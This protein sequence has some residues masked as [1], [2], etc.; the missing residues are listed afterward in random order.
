[1]KGKN[2]VFFLNE[3]FQEFFRF[4]IIRGGKKQA[5]IWTYGK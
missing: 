2:I 1:M 4:K 5:E 3:D